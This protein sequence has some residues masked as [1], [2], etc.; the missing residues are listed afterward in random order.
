MSRL[1]LLSS[2]SRNADYYEKISD[3]LDLSTIEK[4]ILVGYYKTVE[5]FDAD[6]LK[7][8]RNA[9]VF[10]INMKLGFKKFVL[11]NGSR[12]LQIF[13]LFCQPSYFRLRKSA[14]VFKYPWVRVTLYQIV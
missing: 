11:K 4:Q 2:C 6:M 10:L 13:T 14:T 8:F 9:E 12:T 3:P 5:A 1:T 7:V